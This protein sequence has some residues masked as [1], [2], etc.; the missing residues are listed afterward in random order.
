MITRRAVLAASLVLGV[1]T[2]ASGSFA[3]AKG[4][5]VLEIVS[6][7]E[8]TSL[9]LGDTSY[10]FRRLRVAETLVT[11]DP[12]G[13]LAPELAESWSVS[14]D[15]LSWTFVIRD[16]VKFHD[17]S[18]LTPE[19]VRVAIEAMR[20]ANT[21]S[22]LVSKLPIAD[23]RVDGQAVVVTLERPFNLVPDFFTDGPAVILA[24]SSFAQDG[25]V[26]QIIGTGPYRI[27]K[28]G[29]KTSV[30][31]EAFPDY[32]GEQPHIARVHFTGATS[33]D[34]IA[35]MAEAGQADLVLGL[36]QVL[37]DRVEGSGR[38]RVKQVQT[39]RINGVFVNAADMRFDDPVER[40][41]VSLALDRQGIAVALFGNPKAAANQLLSAAFPGWHD[42][43]LPPIRRNVEEA[44]RLLA[45]AGWKPGSDGI[46]AKDGTR[47][48]F[49]MIVGKQPEVASLAEAIQAQLAEIGIEVKLQNGNQGQVLESVS[50]GTLVL[51]MTR[52]NYGAVPDPVATLILDFAEASAGSSPWSGIN[53]HNPKLESALN[54]YI[55]ART[56]EETAAARD[57]ILAV[58]NSDLPVIPVVWYDYNVSISDRV[59]FDSV[60]IDALEVSF[61]IDRV[62]WAE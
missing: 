30:D 36:S 11:I 14:D 24:P 18:L 49:T 57:R 46:L 19:I 61:W 31:L 26:K 34:T 22:E 7:R 53:Y 58:V 3:W 62:R 52:R 33:P 28:I 40:R 56:K 29:G 50:K 59:N 13:K 20:K 25:T 48:A 47:F 6:P 10:H 60:P 51:G 44:R 16:G 27:S 54:A 37:R 15:G 42:A 55:A 8:I 45:E 39:A 23:V 38:V 41:A 17:G 4:D 43:S 9:D 2:A 35:N 32:W 5:R 12:E 1:A 21:N